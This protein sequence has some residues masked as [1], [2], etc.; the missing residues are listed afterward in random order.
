MF[1]CNQSNQW[2][3]CKASVYHGGIQANWRE[4]SANAG[5]SGNPASKADVIHDGYRGDSLLH[6]LVALFGEFFCACMRVLACDVRVF[7][8]QNG[9]ESYFVPQNFSESKLSFY[10]TIRWS[11]STLV[12]ICVIILVTGSYQ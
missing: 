7:V 4:K 1:Y 10:L 6:Q 8:L 12:N 3:I 2:E 5:N 9:D 11:A